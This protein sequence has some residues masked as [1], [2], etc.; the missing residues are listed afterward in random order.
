MEANGK[1]KRLELSKKNCEKVKLI[2]QYPA[3]DRATIK[4]GKVIE[5]YNDCFWFD[6]I[7]DGKTTYSYDFLVEIKEVRE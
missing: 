3:S 6:E 2:F 5:C 7:Y 1:K 4:S